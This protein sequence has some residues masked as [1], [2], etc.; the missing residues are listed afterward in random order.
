LFI[1][2]VVI[3][4]S[5]EKDL[6][7]KVELEAACPLPRALSF[8]GV[9]EIVMDRV[10]SEADK[11]EQKGVPLTTEDFAKMVRQQWDI[12]KKE[13]IPKAVKEYEACKKASVFS[14][15]EKTV[16][17]EQKEDLKKLGVKVEEEG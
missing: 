9:R 11:L 6:E 2:K 15:V 8:R 5:E 16:S 13:D 10:W 3:L 14:E 7:K 4:L 1:L 12:V 17:E